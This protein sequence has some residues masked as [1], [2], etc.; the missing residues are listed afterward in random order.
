MCIGKVNGCA[1]DQV[2]PDFIFAWETALKHLF[3]AATAHA[4]MSV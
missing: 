1:S 2:L 3:K 4:E